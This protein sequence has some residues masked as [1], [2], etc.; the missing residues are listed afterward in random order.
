MLDNKYGESLP[1]PFYSSIVT[2]KRTWGVNGIG[3]LDVLPVTKPNSVKALN[4]TQSTDPNL[5]LI[6][7]LILS[8]AT[9]KLLT[10]RVTI[11]LCWFSYFCDSCAGEKFSTI[12][13]K[14]C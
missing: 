14:T 7:S 11:P 13:R 6:N 10:E 1:L 4:K 5:I 12:A 9:T 2:H 8:S 3:F